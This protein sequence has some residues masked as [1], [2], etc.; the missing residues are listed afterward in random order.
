M[1][2]L[3]NRHLKQ[4]NWATALLFTFC[5]VLALGFISQKSVFW[6]PL[7]I[8]GIGCA[9]IGIISASKL[10]DRSEAADKAKAVA[11]EEARLAPQRAEYKNA[12]A[13]NGIEVASDLLAKYPLA[14]TLS[15]EALFQLWLEARL[16]FDEKRKVYLSFIIFPDISKPIPALYVWEKSS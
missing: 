10:I 15:E 6:W 14:P 11:A 1:H 8:F 7:L 5:I 9:L 12:W 3:T 4:I 13:F 2:T 16:T